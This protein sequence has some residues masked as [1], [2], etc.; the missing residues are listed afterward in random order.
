MFRW[1]KESGMVD[2]NPVS[3]LRKPAARS[4][5]TEALIDPELHRRLLSVVSS[6]FGDFIEAVHA[7]GARPGEIARIEARNIVWDAG[8]AV[9]LEHKT[10]RTGR[11]RTVYLPP[12]ILGLCRKLAAKHPTGPLFRNT[13]G[14]A[15]K[16]TG[17]K[18][19]ME[20]AQRKLG[21]DRRPLTSGYRHT[22]A[23]DA[24]QNGVP[25]AHVAELLGHQGTEMLH[26][27]YAHL[28]AKARVMKQSLSRVR[29]SNG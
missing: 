24:L 5:G 16:K 27:H 14:E 10:D 29:P 7:T 15:W 22:F 6:A 4:R 18:Q 12:H 26:R 19:A 2:V 3:A 13:R 1:A 25:D 17:W 8:C 11:V 9:L 21:L 23:T 28:T 20:R